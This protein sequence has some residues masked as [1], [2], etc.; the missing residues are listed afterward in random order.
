MGVFW[1]PPISV[2]WCP[3]SPVILTDFVGFN[4]NFGYIC[5]F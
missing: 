2:R 4:A 3:L 5:L 1:V